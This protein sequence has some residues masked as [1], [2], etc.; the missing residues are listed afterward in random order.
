MTHIDFNN[1]LSD[2]S[3]NDNNGIASGG[4]YELVN[5]GNYSYKLNGTGEYVRL[6][7]NSLLNPTDGITVSVWIKPEEYGGTGEDAIVAKTVTGNVDPFY[8]Y[9]LGITGTNPDSQGNLRTHYFFFKIAVGGVSKTLY[10]TTHWVADKWYHVVGLYIGSKIKI[11]VNGLLEYTFEGGAII[12]T[13]N[14]D[15]FIGKN[16]VKNSTIPGS[17]D[18]L[19]IYNRGIT[20]PEVWELYQLEKK[21]FP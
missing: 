20:G 6:N 9:N 3:E 7:D 14:T 5:S 2:L 17:I 10:A 18:N 4:S 8:Q 15:V 11:Y 19:R 21:L 13:F 16:P 1:N 12:S